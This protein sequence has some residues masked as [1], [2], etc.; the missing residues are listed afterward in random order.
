MEQ[1]NVS[2]ARE[3][4]RKTRFCLQHTLSEVMLGLHERFAKDT[5][6]HVAVSWMHLCPGYLGHPF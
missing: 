3:K 6:I 2:H 5:F 1:G 4:T